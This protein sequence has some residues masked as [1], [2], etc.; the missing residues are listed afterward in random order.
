MGFKKAISV[1]CWCPSILLTSLYSS[2]AIGPV[3][4]T[5]KLDGIYTFVYKSKK[6]AISFNYVWI[7][8]LIT[9]TGSA[10]NYLIYWVYVEIVD[11]KIMIAKLNEYNNS[12]VILE[13]Y[14]SFKNNVYLIVLLV[15]LIVNMLQIILIQ[16]TDCY[17]SWCCICFKSNCLPMTEINI[18]DVD[19]LDDP[20]TMEVLQSLEVRREEIQWEINFKDEIQCNSVDIQIDT[21]IFML[22]KE[23]LAV[24]EYENK[25]VQAI[26]DLQDATIQTC[27]D[28]SNLQEPPHTYILYM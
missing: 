2:F 9:S 17:H 27:M 12:V 13:L 22:E 5:P 15:L 7:N 10:L 25:S 4:F 18:L 21:K 20:Q 26:P 8:V 28:L 11:E 6:L 1:I 14:T 19:N 16:C 3:K 24:Q 23:I